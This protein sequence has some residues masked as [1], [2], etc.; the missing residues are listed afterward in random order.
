MIDVTRKK[1]DMFDVV[2]QEHKTVLDRFTADDSRI[3][4]V[5]MSYSFGV[6]NEQGTVLFVPAS[7]V[8]RTTLDKI[9]NLLVH[10]NA[11]ELA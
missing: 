10:L 1:N 6:K 9:Q 3:C 8:K 2:P 5:K 11:A 4:F 7:D